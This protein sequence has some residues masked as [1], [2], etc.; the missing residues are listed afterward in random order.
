MAAAFVAAPGREVYATPM[1]AW[2]PL[3]YDPAV[4]VGGAELPL[5]SG[6]WAPLRE[7]SMLYRGFRAV[8]GTPG[9]FFADPVGIVRTREALLASVGEGGPCPVSREGDV[10]VPLG[11]PDWSNEHTR[12]VLMQCARQWVSG[13]KVRTVAAGVAFERRWP[14]GGGAEHRRHG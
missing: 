5:C 9:A 7:L 3:N 14:G 1:A 12:T 2:L 13:G 11:T 6:G 10:A 4:F 8:T